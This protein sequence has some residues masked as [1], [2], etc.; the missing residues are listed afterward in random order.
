MPM[1]MPS[2][3]LVMPAVGSAIE[4][5]NGRSQMLYRG[6]VLSVDGNKVQVQLP[7]ADDRPFIFDLTSELV[8]YEGGAIFTAW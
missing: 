3:S 2:S 6:T 5:E 8:T 4:V 7:G 1:N